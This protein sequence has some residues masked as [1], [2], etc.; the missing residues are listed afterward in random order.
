MEGSA[1]L[2]SRREIYFALQFYQTFLIQTGQS[3]NEEKKRQAL[4][5]AKPNKH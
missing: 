1:P 4:H 3:K 2:T 5:N